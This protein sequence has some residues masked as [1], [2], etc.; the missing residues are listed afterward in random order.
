MDVNLSFAAEEK[1]EC[2]EFIEA[3]K[4]VSE[5]RAEP[6]SL[7]GGFHWETLDINDPMVV[8]CCSFHC[9]TNKVFRPSAAVSR[10]DAGVMYVSSL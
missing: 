2:N 5:I 7:P 6:Y 9:Q 8:R 4:P 10:D 3:D 1:I